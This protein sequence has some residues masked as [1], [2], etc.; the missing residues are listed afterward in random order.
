MVVKIKV[1][2]KNFNEQVSEV[3]K[4]PRI[5]RK[6]VS[7]QCLIFY[8]INHRRISLLSLKCVMSMLFLG[9]SW[10]FLEQTTHQDGI[11]SAPPST[12]PTLRSISFHLM[13]QNVTIEKKEKWNSNLLCYESLDNTTW[14][15]EEGK[16]GRGGSPFSPIWES[17]PRQ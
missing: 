3:V 4:I 7:L 16:D 12:K 15:P 17:F 14:E 5:D 8:P 11:R 1:N 9:K 10:L 13:A 6:I 2:P